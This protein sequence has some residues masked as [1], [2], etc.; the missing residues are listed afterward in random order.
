MDSIERRRIAHAR[1]LIAG[2]P[3]TAD[4]MGGSE[5]AE[6]HVRAACVS[7]ESVP[8]PPWRRARRAIAIFLYAWGT[9]ALANLSEERRNFDAS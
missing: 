8:P 3:A 2:P 9:A 7:P 5:K 1:Y 4:T 6:P